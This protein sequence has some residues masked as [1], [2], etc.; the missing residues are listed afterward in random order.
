METKELL[1]A[2]Q[3]V[4][5]YA[6]TILYTITFYLAAFTEPSATKKHYRIYQVAQ[7]ETG[8]PVHLEA[9]RDNSSG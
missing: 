1:K 4:V 6:I 7:V 2:P 5:V 9:V 8:R 3:L